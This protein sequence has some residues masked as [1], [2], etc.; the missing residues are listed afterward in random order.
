ME[1]FFN[2]ESDAEKWVVFGY[3]IYL[4][5]ETE[6]CSLRFLVCLWIAFKFDVAEYVFRSEGRAGYV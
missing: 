2:S 1:V 6:E 4:I 3:C 5:A